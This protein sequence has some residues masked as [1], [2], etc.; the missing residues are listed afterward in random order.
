[1]KIKTAQ[2]KY[3]VSNFEY[4]YEQISNHFDKTADFMIFPDI[5]TGDK[6]KID[7]RYMLKKNEFFEKL[8]TTFN[9]KTFLIGCN[10]IK[11]GKLLNVEDCFFN[12]NDK[13]FYISKMFNDSI[14]CD[15]YIL[16]GKSYYAKGSHQKLLENTVT[17]CNLIYV[18]PIMLE[19]ENV[20]AG[21][22]FVKN[23]DNELVY[24]AELLKETVFDIYFNKK[25]DLYNL[26][27]IEEIYRVTTFALKEYCDIIGFKEVVLGLS[28]GID[29]AV[30][31]VLAS[32]ALGA[33]NVYTIMMPSK[34]SSEGSITDSQKL[35]D[36]LGIKVET[37]AIKDLFDCFMNTQDSKHDL[38]EENLQSRLRGLILMFNSNRYNR[39]LL[40]TGNKSEIACGYGTLYGDMCGGLNLIADLT[41]TNV[42]KLA[43][44]INRERKIIPQE[45]IDKPPSAELRP[46]QKDSDSLPEYDIL[47]KIIEDFVEQELPYEELINKYEKATVDKTLKLIYR[48]QFKRNQACMGIRLTE[49]AFCSNINLPVL[50]GLQ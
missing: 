30:T 8:Y 9:D 26:S 48:A 31:A 25:E 2:I 28:G 39:L 40:S 47:D 5:E 1:M 24:Q 20:Y 42:Y 7:S 22:S 3:R 6:L 4:N 35:V 11:N 23:S 38:A 29:S 45:I 14:E 12:I 41:K 46:D 18:N 32:E 49:N 33:K 36:N 17:N 50:Q 21:Q 44:F 13:K 16:C 37:R 34:Y 19:D 15:V 43:N 27:D 10:L